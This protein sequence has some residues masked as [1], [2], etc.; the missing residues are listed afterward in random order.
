MVE[1]EARRVARWSSAEWGRRGSA[2][3]DD[4]DRSAR[5]G[6]KTLR[7]Q[8]SDLASHVRHLLHTT[9]GEG[10]ILAF[11]IQAA[12]FALGIQNAN[13]DT[14]IIKQKSK[15]FSAKLASDLLRTSL[16][17]E[18]PVQKRSPRPMHLRSTR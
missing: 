4:H 13:P 6:V 11:V 2:F 5:K 16:V 12:G 15:Q 9:D 17:N 8:T 18:R 1:C 10:L 14:G 7:L 3:T